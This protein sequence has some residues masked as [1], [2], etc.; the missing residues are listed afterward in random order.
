MG[1]VMH[2]LSI[3]C[4]RN[5]FLKID[6]IRKWRIFVVT[7]QIFE[8]M[9]WFGS[10]SLKSDRPPRFHERD[11]LLVLQIIVSRVHIRQ[12]NLSLVNGGG[13]FIIF[14]YDSKGPQNI[15]RNILSF[16][17]DMLIWEEAY[18]MGVQMRMTF[19]ESNGHKTYR[20]RW[21]KR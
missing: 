5:K 14:H 10:Q 1:L 15:E 17:S 13:N 19:C 11:F 8:S 6:V 4:H 20:S 21:L 12:C 18:I 16:S 9:K 7:T 3:K 2:L